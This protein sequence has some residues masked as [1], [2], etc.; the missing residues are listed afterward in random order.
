MSNSEVG[1]VVLDLIDWFD[2]LN[3][4]FVDHWFGLT[5][6]IHEWMSVQFKQTKIGWI[7][8]ENV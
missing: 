5:M 6:G 7:R 3:N 2:F 4:V 1:S 8:F